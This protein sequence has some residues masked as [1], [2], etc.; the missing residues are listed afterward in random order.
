MKDTGTLAIIHTQSHGCPLIL[1]S[2]FSIAS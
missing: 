1:R 2:G